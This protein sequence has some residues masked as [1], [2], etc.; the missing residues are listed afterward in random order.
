MNKIKNIKYGRGISR[1]FYAVN[2]INS[3]HGDTDGVLTWIR[4]LKVVRNID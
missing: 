3:Q 2:I 4:N 1:A